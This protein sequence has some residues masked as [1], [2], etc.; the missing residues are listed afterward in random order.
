MSTYEIIQ[1]H[2]ITDEEVTDLIIT[3]VE[4]MGAGCLL[5]QLTDEQREAHPGPAYSMRVA[6]ALLADE[7]VHVEDCW[8]YSSSG[9]ASAPRREA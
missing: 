2:T 8:G 1:T 7:E 6:Q 3:A 4:H 5:Y 9:S